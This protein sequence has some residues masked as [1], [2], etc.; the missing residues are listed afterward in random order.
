MVIDHLYFNERLAPQPDTDQRTTQERENSSH[1]TAF[2]G[3]TFFAC[4]Y[5]SRN[6]ITKI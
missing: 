5:S 2:A 6:F 4:Y 1:V 3:P